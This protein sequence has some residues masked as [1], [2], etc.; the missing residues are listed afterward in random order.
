VRGFYFVEGVNAQGDRI[1]S[2]F[3]VD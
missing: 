3:V 2:R 1:Q